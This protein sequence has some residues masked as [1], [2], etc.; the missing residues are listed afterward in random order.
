MWWGSSVLIGVLTYELHP[1]L[2]SW[3]ACL[4]QSQP[5][6]ERLC[7]LPCFKLLRS[8]C[9]VKRICK[10]SLIAAHALTVLL[11]G[12]TDEVLAFKDHM[13]PRYPGNQEEA[14]RLMQNVLRVQ[15][16]TN[17]YMADRTA[18]LKEAKEEAGRVLARI[19]QETA[20][21][22]ALVRM[23]HAPRGTQHYYPG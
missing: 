14:A 15:A 12:A 6:G 3:H 10:R 5:L 21:A 11:A 9:T 13:E 1:S 19:Q 2:L 20:R 7:L 16:A 8:D 4:A 23:E 22:Q 18:A 17:T